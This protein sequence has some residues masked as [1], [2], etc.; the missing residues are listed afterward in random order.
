[1]KGKNMDS[2][3]SIDKSVMRAA[4]AESARVFFRHCGAVVA[5]F[6]LGIGVG[7]LGMYWVWMTKLSLTAGAAS[8]VYPGVVGLMG[9]AA[10][11]FAWCGYKLIAAAAK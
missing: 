10:V 7:I 3:A 8:L 4:V 9:A 11:V 5:S 1:M 6:A 2:A